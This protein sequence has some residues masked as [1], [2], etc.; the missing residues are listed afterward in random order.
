LPGGSSRRRG[1]APVLMA[2]C[3]RGNS[4][5][6]KF[7]KWRRLLED[8]I[9]P[10]ESVTQALDLMK[11]GFRAMVAEDVDSIETARR[12]AD[13]PS[14]VHRDLKVF[15]IIFGAG[16]KS[17]NPRDALAS[18]ASG[19]GYAARL[20]GSH[21]SA[22]FCRMIRHRWIQIARSQPFSLV[23][24]RLSVPEILRA[25]SPKLFGFHSAPNF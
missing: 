9:G 10:R 12:I 20:R 1:P 19:L 24:P 23:A 6:P 11:I 18:Q 22:V 16:L 4:E 8:T 5:M 15:P 13:D 14:G 3:A 21:W 7:H 2:A 25:S 17:V